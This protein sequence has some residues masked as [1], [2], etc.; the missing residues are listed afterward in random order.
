[1]I[2]LE[3]QT[4]WAKASKTIGMVQH[5]CS[6]LKHMGLITH[7][8][9]NREEPLTSFSHDTAMSLFLPWP[10]HLTLQVL[11]QFPALEWRFYLS[12]LSSLN[13]CR[14]HL[15]HQVSFHYCFSR[16]R[17]SSNLHTFDSCSSCPWCCRCWMNL[18]LLYQAG[19]PTW[20]TIVC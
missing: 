1:M 9:F 20:I 3:V 19:W 8:F 16:H 18:R 12:L 5:L 17:C 4:G 13:R 7:L 10:T 11:L 6:W 2:T 14:I 15:A